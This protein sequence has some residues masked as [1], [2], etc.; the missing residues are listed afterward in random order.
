MATIV[1]NETD[2]GRQKY[3]KKSLQRQGHQVWLADRLDQINAILSDVSAQ[4]L[5]IDLDR[6]NL[7]AVTQFGERWKGVKILFQTSDSDLRYDFRT[8]MA[9]QFVLKEIST[10]KMQRAIEHLVGSNTTNGGIRH[11]N[12]L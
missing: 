3:L 7:D 8:W 6:Q 12:Y 11:A 1:L 10:E 4:M 2:P 5:S 9:D